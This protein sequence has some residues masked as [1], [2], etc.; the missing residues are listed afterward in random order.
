MK[1]QIILAFQEKTTTSLVHALSQDLTQVFGQSITISCIYL[2]ELPEDFRILGDIILVTH[3]TVLDQLK[4]HVDD[5]NR[6]VVISRTVTEEAIYQLYD[7]PDGADVLIV[8][9]NREL[10]NETVAMLYQ[11]GVRH[12]HMIPY[13]PGETDSSKILFAVTPGE[14]RYVPSNIPNVI[15]IGNRRL[16]MQTFLDILAR[17]NFSSN[18]ITQALIQYSNTVVELHTGVKQRYLQS[19]RLG[20]SL[21]QILNLQ[22]IGILMTEPD[23]SLT[24]WNNTSS[25]IFDEKLSLGCSLSLFFPESTAEK[26]SS[27]HFEKDFLSIGEENY[28]IARE[29]ICVMGCLTGY[30]FTLE[31]ASK[32]RKSGQELRK[33]FQ[34]KGRIAHYTFQDIIFQSTIME[35]CITL[36]KKAANSN[37]SIMLT[38]ES[39]TGKELFAQSIHNASTRCNAP[40]VAINCAALPETLLE[41]ELFGYEEGAFTGARRNGKLGLFEQAD[42]G[43]LF[44]DEIGD[45]PYSLQAKLLRVLQ[46]KQVVRLGG[47]TAI[48]VDVRILS[49]TNADLRDLIRNKKF[50]E[51]LF[52]RLN[53]IP[54]SIPA[55]RQR[56]EDILPLFT[57][58]CKMRESEIPNNIVKQL[59]TYSWPGNVRELHNA[60]AYYGLMGTL[61][62]L[63]QE[64]Q[65]PTAQGSLRDTILSLLFERSQAGKHTGRGSLKEALSERNIFISENR[66]E[67]I[68]RDLATE[69]LIIRSRGAGGIRLVDAE[70]QNGTD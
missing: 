55:L 69:G 32:I 37:L 10:T 51:D 66:I 70:T 54:L 4:S 28:I 3:P 64:S 48:H 57:N 58:F 15:D 38:G 9:A 53:V 13:F 35:Q 50:R 41:S 21:Q 14:C 23:L 62:C 25:R 60:A 5:I 11:L 31:S 29:N 33:N 2:N 43:T 30:C 17:I 1:K 39:G 63:K 59:L 18:E 26:L 61:A 16:D 12:I 34:K 27:T 20:E 6:V 8:N 45:M 49:A 22:H 24:F 65:Q 7:I 52:Y 42:G 44:L 40:F 46:E 36:A 56:K 19:Y 47:D 67:H 68:L